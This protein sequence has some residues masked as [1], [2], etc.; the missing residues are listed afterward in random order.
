MSIPK[1]KKLYKILAGFLL[2]SANKYQRGII[3]MMRVTEQ[4]RYTATVDALNRNQIQ[5]EKSQT[6]LSTGKNIQTTSENVYGTVNSIYYRTRLTAISQFESNIVDAKERLDVSY[7][8]MG[9]VVD[10]LHRS[11]ELALQASNG[12]LDSF[13]RKVIAAEVEQMIER[14]YDV[15]LT[16]S[17]GEYVFSGTNVS[18]RP[19]MAFYR[20]NDEMGREVMVNVSYEGN[21]YAQN[22]EIE[23]SQ[24]VDIGTPGNYAFWAGNMEIIS[25]TNS[26]EYIAD[27]NQKIMIDD[28][29]ITIKQGDN[30][31]TIVERIN[32]SGVNVKASIGQLGGEEKVIQLTTRQPHKILLQ[33]IEGGSVFQ[34]IGLIRDG[35]PNNSENNYAVDAIVNSKSVFEVLI[36][37]RDA[38]LTNDTSTI[39]GSSIGYI[40]EAINNVVVNQSR[41]SAIVSRLDM[42]TEHFSVQRVSSTEALSKIEDVNY[43]EES[44]IFSSWEYV[45]K[46]S[47][48]TASKLMNM[49]L[50]DYIR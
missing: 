32:D 9:Q 7:S 28:T 24:F 33:D 36:D 23:D 8:S 17:K 50:M 22:R 6:R 4:S 45:H 26:A 5:L 12:V 13:D 35:V 19:F 38:M 47:L 27:R 30:L 41:V 21:S 16:K 11:R 42:A 15:S 20:Q 3:I 34:D 49:S 48:L 18:S 44:V 10:A 37:L 31:D 40:D 1:Y 2:H 25:N 46:A 39:G 43:A 14:I 29:V